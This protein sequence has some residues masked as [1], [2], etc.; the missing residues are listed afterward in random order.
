MSGLP[1][2]ASAPLGGWGRWPVL[3]CAVARP[4]TDAELRRAIAA[5]PLIARGAGRA[6][7]DSALQ[8]A[9]TALTEG[10]GRAVDLDPATGVMVCD[11]GALLADALA[12]A[13]PQGW[14]PPVTPGTRFVSIGGALA[15]DVHGKNHHVA[16]SLGEHVSWLELITADGRALRC[17]P[18]EHAPLF[19]AT[20]GGMGLTGVIRRAAIRM[21]PVETAW[22]RQ[23]TIVARDLDAAF[24]A[25]EASADWTYSVAWID[26]LARGRNLGRALLHRGEHARRDE[27]PPERR[28]DPLRLPPRRAVAMPF[29]APGGLLNAATARLLNLAYWERNRRRTAPRLVD[30]ESFFYPL[31]GI[32]HW[33]RLYGRRGFLQYQCVLPLEASGRGLRVMLERIA[34]SGVGSFL[35][36]LKLMGEGRTAGLS[37][38][39]RGYTLALDFPASRRLMALL[40]ELDAVALDHGG[41][42]YLA[43]DA[44]MAA[45]TC[46]RGYPGAAAFEE[47][48]RAVGAAGVFRSRQ[49]ERLGFA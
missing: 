6:Y 1:G 12:A 34:R 19:A 9:C 25:F 24:A 44:R 16:G 36:V 22:V 45:A 17:S 42:I 13:V 15:A 2:A 28:A 48:R 21:L 43:K 38:P 39:M 10:L 31:D 41:R 18:Q 35:A 4:S 49:S 3:P 32:L 33:N 8:P 20:L 7:G 40:D 46:W 14:F 37:F 30:Y 27:L 47:L 29:D 11:G 23:E 26:A 5:G